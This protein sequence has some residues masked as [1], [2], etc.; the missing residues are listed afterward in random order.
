MRPILYDICRLWRMIQ[1]HVLPCPI[2]GIPPAFTNP[3]QSSP[4]TNPAPRHD[5]SFSVSKRIWR[6]TIHCTHIYLDYPIHFYLLLVNKWKKVQ[7]LTCRKKKMTPRSVIL[8]RQSRM[9]LTFHFV[10]MPVDYSVNWRMREKDEEER[11]ENKNRIILRGNRHLICQQYTKLTF[12]WSSR[13]HSRRIHA[14]ADW[15]TLQLIFIL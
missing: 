3:K 14:Y 8:E 15:L 2:A 12:S 7:S 1:D 13:C 11:G 5:S 9:T 10:E 6:R 4:P